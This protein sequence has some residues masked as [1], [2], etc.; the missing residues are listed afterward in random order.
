MLNLGNY[1]LL[2][3]EI[4][5]LNERPSINDSIVIHCVKSPVVITEINYGTKPSLDKSEEDYC[6]TPDWYRIGL[7]CDTN[8]SSL[9]L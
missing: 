8:V 5:I 3:N 7:P 6:Y 2:E 1:P 4:E 9:A